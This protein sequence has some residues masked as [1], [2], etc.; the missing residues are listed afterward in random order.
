M[1]EQILLTPNTFREK[2]Q[3]FWY[4]HKWHTIA[5]VFAVFVSVVLLVQCMNTPNPDYS[6]IIAIDKTLPMG[7][8]ARLEEAFKPYGEDLNG[9]GQVIVQFIDCSTEEKT[10][11]MG[12]GRMSKFMAEMA[13]GE[14]ILIIVDR[15]RYDYLTETNDLFDT[16]P[17]FVNKNGTAYNIADG[18]VYNAVNEQDF[19]PKNLYITKRKSGNAKT[20]KIENSL[21]L[22]E[23]FI[24]DNPQPQP[25]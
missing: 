20:E 2:L 4:H 21:K 23:K 15:S 7:Y 22:L 18:K 10:S 12:S 25:E 19:L 6:I 8:T 9:D 1:P 17:L 14:V 24:A 3:N 13:G 11:Q 16:N 5:G